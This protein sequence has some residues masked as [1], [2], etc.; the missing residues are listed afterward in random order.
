MPLITNGEQKNLKNRLVELINKSEELKFLVGF[1]YFSGIKELYESLKAKTD[2]NIKVLVGL[3]VDKGLFGLVEYGDSEKQLSDE[4][5]SQRFLESVKKSINSENFDIK[6]FYEQ[7]KFFLDLIAKDKLIIRKTYNPNHSKLY[8]FRL[9]DDQ[10]RKNFYITGSSNLTKAGLITQDELNIELSDFGFDEAEK[11]FNDLWSEAVKITEDDQIKQRLINLIEKETLVKE[12]TPFEAF[13]YILKTYLDSFKQKDV[14][15]S[16]LKLME[17]KGYTPYTYQI[18]AIK[19]ALA[20]IDENDGVIIADVVGLGKSVIASA[21]AYEMGRRGIVI[22]PPGLAGDQNGT[23]GWTKYLEDFQLYDWKVR[24]NGKLEEVA[25][26][27]RDNP[28]IE[29]II[30]DEVHRFRNEDTQDYEYLKNICRGKKIML[31]TATPFNNKPADILSLLELFI[32]PKKSRITL[33][34]NIKEKFKTFNG[35]FN[36]LAF[37]KKNYNSPNA[38]LKRKAEDIYQ[39]LFGEK[40]IT[41]AKVKERA[42]YLAKQIRGVIEPVIIRRNRIDLTNNPEYKKEVVNLSKLEDPKEWYYELTEEQSAFYDLIIKDFFA[43]PDEGGR[44]KGAIY[45]PF[46]YEVTKEKI[47]GEKLNAAENF[48]FYSQRNLFEFMRRLLVKRFESSFGSFEQSIKN[49]KKINTNALAFINKTQ[50]YILDRKLLE[51]IVEDDLDAQQISQLLEDFSKELLKGSYPKN[52]RIYELDKFVYKNEFIRDIESDSALFDEILSKLKTL[53]LVKND[54]KSACLIDKIKVVL[55]E[56]PLQGEPCRKVVIFTEYGDT[57]QYLEKILKN[58]FGNR[59]L[60]ITGDLPVSKIALI[61]HNFDA[62]ARDQENN[63]DILLSTDRISEGFN[64]NRAGM[65]INYDIPWNPVRV[66]QRVGRINRISKKV[67]KS[68]QIVNFFPSELGATIVRSREIAQYK[69]FLIHSTLGEDSKIFDIDEE[70]TA[71][72]F[73]DKIQRNPDAIEEESFY[74]KIS[75]IFRTIADKNPDLVKQLETF[76]TRIKVAKEYSESSLLV[77][78]RKGRLYVKECANDSNGKSSA[79]SVSLEQ[80][81]AKIEC[82]SDCPAIP[83]SQQFWTNYEYVKNFKETQASGGTEQNIEQRAMNVLAW[84]IGNA[85]AEL[86][87]FALF[88]RTLREDIIDYGTLPSATLRRISNL[89]TDTEKEKNDTLG[90]IKSLKNELGENYLELEKARTNSLKQEVI[91]A[92]ENQKNA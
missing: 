41:L 36:K 44:F 91:I 6:E 53:D 64:L 29:V 54:P 4:E 76:P 3:N 9:G 86:V 71:S 25:E 88:L 77:F 85:W 49:F 40:D 7:I 51:Q 12:I 47:K 35:I 2:V 87:P 42:N 57:A 82:A 19:Q 75:R 90:E 66:I 1:F 50:K 73:F 70:P 39:S 74:T 46:E 67:F 52:N 28:S 8:I 63:Y 27:V 11:Y 18:D 58:V 24:S 10:V 23:S 20:I 69:M 62:S 37:V 60:A 68:L 81:F 72:R 61:N 16:L 30:I 21:V 92:V 32:V 26:F 83:L 5:R 38:E 48:E 45:H 84:L 43:D 15:T 33:E 78:I 65:V 13:A 80:S 31:L 34:N 14:R 79:E 89:K 17:E 22:C 55:K 59:V 56:K